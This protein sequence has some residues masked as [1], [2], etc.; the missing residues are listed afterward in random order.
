MTTASPTVLKASGSADFLATLPAVAGFTARNSVVVALFVGSRSYGALRIDL[1][2]RR[3]TSDFRALGD[4]I[5]DLA[6]QV[7]GVDGVVPVV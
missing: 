4:A 7:P 2:G 3:R 6:T 5:V 1:P